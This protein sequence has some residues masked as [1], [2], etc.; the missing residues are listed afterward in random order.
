[1]KIKYL[2]M[3]GNF[4]IINYQLILVL[5]CLFY[6]VVKIKKNYYSIMLKIKLCKV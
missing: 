1:M 2:Y 5:R 3:I 4:K 6:S